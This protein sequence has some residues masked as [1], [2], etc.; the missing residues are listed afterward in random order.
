[1]LLSLQKL[2]S[3][4]QKCHQTAWSSFIARGH[5]LHCHSERGCRESARSVRE[6][7]ASAA[8]AAGAAGADDGAELTGGGSDQTGRRSSTTA[9]DCWR[10]MWGTINLSGVE[11]S[12]QANHD[13][14][15]LWASTCSLRFSITFRAQIQS[16]SL[17]RSDLMPLTRLPA[18]QAHTRCCCPLAAA[19][20]TTMTTNKTSSRTLFIYLFRL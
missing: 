19:L 11:Y 16:S 12:L 7:P 8:A 2:Q 9:H 4:I 15:F 10:T 13:F 1:M 6:Q 5:L 14:F 20:F 3:F 18:A 17:L